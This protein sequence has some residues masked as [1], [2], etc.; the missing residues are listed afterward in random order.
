MSN[1][2]KFTQEDWASWYERARTHTLVAPQ[3]TRDLRT[4]PATAALLATAGATLAEMDEDIVA[5]EFLSKSLGV[6]S[7]SQAVTA[8]SGELSA[9]A[10][11]LLQAI[12]EAKN[13][14]SAWD[15]TSFF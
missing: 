9:I 6:S 3:L 5:G 8:I 1:A 10:Q 11:D 15:G 7:A 2:S 13:G 14:Q 4:A 12:V